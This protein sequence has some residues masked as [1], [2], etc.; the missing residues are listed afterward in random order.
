MVAIGVGMEH[1]I[2]EASHATLA[3]DTLL[4]TGGGIVLWISAFLLLLMASV[5]RLPLARAA[6]VYALSVAAT[7]LVVALG[8]LVP[9]LPTLAGLFLVFF[10]LV[11]VDEYTWTYGRDRLLPDWRRPDSTPQAPENQTEKQESPGG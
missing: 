5:Q 11:L 1:A 6:L 7:L 9:P 3:T 8:A 10:A 4:L 2:T